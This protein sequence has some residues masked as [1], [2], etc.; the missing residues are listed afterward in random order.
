M[1]HLKDQFS[2]CTNCTYD[3]NNWVLSLDLGSFPV[4][5]E[6]SAPMHPRKYKRVMDKIVVGTVNNGTVNGTAYSQYE[7]MKV[8]RKGRVPLRIVASPLGSV[9]TFMR[10]F[11]VFRSSLPFLVF[12]LLAVNRTALGLCR[13]N[14]YGVSY[15][16]SHRFSHRDIQHAA[17]RRPVGGRHG[18]LAC[19]LNFDVFRRRRRPSPSDP[20]HHLYRGP[21]RGPH[22]RH[23]LRLG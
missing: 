17:D 19:R 3:F 22:H 4:L 23:G 9:L 11:L 1:Q 13:R 12:R 10:P 21:D 5:P 14:R 2:T 15:R 18:P 7:L 6:S 16:L 8:S 20:S